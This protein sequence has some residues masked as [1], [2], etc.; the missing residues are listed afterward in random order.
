MMD[1]MHRRCLM[2]LAERDPEAF[3]DLARHD[4]LRVTYRC[5]HRED[6]LTFAEAPEGRSGRLLRSVRSDQACFECR[7]AAQV[8]RARGAHDGMAGL[9][10]S[11][12][13]VLFAEECRRDT[14]LQLEAIIEHTGEDAT[15]GRVPADWP[16]RT[17]RVLA[18]L[19]RQPSARWWMDHKFCNEACTAARAAMREEP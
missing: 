1:E 16:A 4:W 17:A 5:G 14:V 19:V 18:W 10:G 3:N 8:A 13:E 9:E 11:D 6:R 15:E 2:D 7:R 12:I